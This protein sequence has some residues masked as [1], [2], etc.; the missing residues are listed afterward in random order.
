MRKPSSVVSRC[1]LAA[2]VL[3][4]VAACGASG[5]G[6]VSLPSNAAS[7][8]DTPTPPATAAPTSGA[9]PGGA[10]SPAGGASS[11]AST[12]PTGAVVANNPNG[13]LACSG[14]TLTL[15]TDKA[16]YT[17][18]EPVKM[19]AT[20]RNPGASACS[21]QTSAQRGF[22]VAHTGAA[23]WRSGCSSSSAG[24]SS[25]QSCPSFVTQTP[26]RAGSSVSRTQTWGQQADT[27]LKQV[28]AGSYTVQEAWG[29]LVATATITIS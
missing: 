9:S 7:P 1:L 20:V 17:A 15:T 21:L 14:L 22:S 10:A 27:S 24:H 13:T 11:G 18:G 12:S 23:V 29:G 28:A 2:T 16:T 19:S 5:G 6:A 4:A 3:L 8:A 26:V 25:A